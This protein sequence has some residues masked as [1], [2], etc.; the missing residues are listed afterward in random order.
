MKVKIETRGLEELR[1]SVD[2]KTAEIDEAGRE[3]LKRAGMQIL[4]TAKENLQKNN[5]IATGQVRNSGVVEGKENDID[6]VFKSLHASAVEF[7]RR[8]GK[9]PPID[10]ILE[11]IKK[12][13][14]IDTYSIKTRKQT[15]RGKNFYK[16]AAALAFLIARKIGKFGVKA[17]PFLYPA[18]RQNEDEVMKILTNSIRKKL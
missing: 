7:G 8:A 3:G 2:K 17:R 1:R 6:V 9:Q 15:S 13:G 10:N 12:K 5:S 16:K 4:A 11:W 14:I 18:F